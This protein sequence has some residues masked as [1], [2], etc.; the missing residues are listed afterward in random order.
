MKRS[1][2]FPVAGS[3]VI[4]TVLSAFPVPSVAQTAPTPGATTMIAEPT[5]LTQTLRLPGRVKALTLAEVRP[6]VSGVISERLFEEG[7]AVKN[8]E[9]T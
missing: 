6:Q 4:A 8:G 5:D 7:A 9:R 1:P 2:R 3:L